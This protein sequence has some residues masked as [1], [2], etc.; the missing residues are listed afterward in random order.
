MTVLLNS[1]LQILNSLRY[2]PLLALRAVLHQRVHQAQALAVQVFLAP[3]LRLFR[4]LQAAQARLAQV[5]QARFLRV[6]A[7]LPAFRVLAAPVFQVQALAVQ[8]FQV[9]VAPAFHHR[10]AAVALF[11]VPVLPALAL[12]VRH[13]QAHFHLLPAVALHLAQVR[14]PAAVLVFHHLQALRLKVS[15]LRVAVA[16]ALVA[17]AAHHAPARFRQAQVLAHRLFLALAVLLFRVR[18]LHLF[19]QAQAA[20]RVS[21]LRVRVVFPAQAPAVR[22]SAPA[23]LAQAAQAHFL[24]LVLR[25]SALRVRVPQVFPAL[26]RQVLARQVSQAL[27]AVPA[28]RVHFLLLARQVSPALVHPAF[29]PAVQALRASAQAPLAFPAL[30]AVLHHC[31]F[32]LLQAQV[33]VAWE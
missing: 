18:V 29:R 10:P 19:L 32:H 2:V 4:V 20:L 16:P 14:F 11:R 21:A 25:A 17:L 3:V 6:R 30:Q 5:A 9:P 1:K 13:A 22:V 26:A 28:V 33:Q 8:V 7:A 15:A 31:P 12:A 27:P 24:L 23:R